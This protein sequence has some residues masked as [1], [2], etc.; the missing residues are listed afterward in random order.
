LRLNIRQ[1]VRTVS[2][3]LKFTG[4]YNKKGEV[5]KV[6]HCQTQSPIKIAALL[7]T[8]LSIEQLKTCLK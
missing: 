5:N 4:S 7:Y 3:N 1:T 8:V 2:L 6:K